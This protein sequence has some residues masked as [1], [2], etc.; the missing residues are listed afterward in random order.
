LILESYDV[1]SLCGVSHILTSLANHHLKPEIPKL[2]LDQVRSKCNSMP[3]YTVLQASF[4]NAVTREALVAAVDSE[5][6]CFKTLS[7]MFSFAA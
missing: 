7:D 5:T 2:T 4:K 1:A 3:A 6:G